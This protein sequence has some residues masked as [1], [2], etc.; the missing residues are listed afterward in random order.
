MFNFWTF[1]FTC[2]QL[3]YKIYLFAFIF[4]IFLNFLS[5]T[6]FY[7][8]CPVLLQLILLQMHIFNNYIEYLVIIKTEEWNKHE[9]LQLNKWDI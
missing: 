7:R 6:D 8:T 4:Y 3:F 2:V 1:F 5:K 9:W